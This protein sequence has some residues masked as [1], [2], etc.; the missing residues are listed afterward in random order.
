MSR[1]CARHG[2]L[3]MKKRISAVSDPTEPPRATLPEEEEEISVLRRR[4]W[5]RSPSFLRREGDE[6][7]QGAAGGSA[8]GNCCGVSS[9]NPAEHLGVGKDGDKPRDFRCETFLP[10]F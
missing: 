6:L 2:P 1:S 3:R 7:P 8:V 10:S 9:A 4:C 5:P